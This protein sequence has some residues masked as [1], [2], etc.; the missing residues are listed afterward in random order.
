ML[1][2]I[3]LQ[4]RSQSAESS[5]VKPFKC[6]LFGCSRTFPTTVELFQHVRDSASHKEEC[7]I[8]CPVLNCQASVMRKLWIAGHK[9]WCHHFREHQS[10]GEVT[11]MPTLRPVRPSQPSCFDLYYQIMEAN[12]LDSCH[13]TGQIDRDNGII[14]PVEPKL[15]PPSSMENEDDH[16]YQSDS[17]KDDRSNVYHDKEMAIN[18]I[19]E[20]LS[21][22][23]S[24]CQQKVLDPRSIG[25]ALLEADRRPLILEE[26]K[27]YWSMYSP[28]FRFQISNLMYK[29][30][31]RY[32]HSTKLGSVGLRCIEPEDFDSGLSLENSCP[33]NTVLDLDNTHLG[34]LR[35]RQ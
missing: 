27:K 19:Q 13:I 9:H 7:C 8:L 6:W 30:A 28:T 1:K 29:V 10:K 22:L 15:N 5:H 3:Q 25:S 31:R 32:D 23:T 12:F 26:N 33:Y 24:M 21:T 11:G 16:Q 4:E 35:S 34:R 14:D 17:E 2:G 20:I 18:D